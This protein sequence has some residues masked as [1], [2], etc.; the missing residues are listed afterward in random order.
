MRTYP[1]SRPGW[2]VVAAPLL[3]AAP[4]ALA[5]DSGPV[6]VPSAP[7]EGSAPVVAVAAA[8]GALD[9]S[10][11]SAAA[12]ST[13]APALA[14][15]PVADDPVLVGA[16]DIAACG[17]GSE[18]T[19][20]LLD[21][22]PGT[23]VTLGDNAYGSGTAEEYA[24]CYE[25]TWGRHKARTRPAPGNHDYMTASAAPY[26]A[27]FG[28]RAGAPRQSYYSYDLGAWHIVALNSNCDEVGGCEAGS[29]QERWLRVDLAAHPAACTLAY[30]HHPRF[31][32]G[33][34][35]NNRAVQ[36]FWQALYDA[37][38]DVALAGHEHFYERFA[39]QDPAGAA[40]PARGIRQFT[41]G[42]GG[43]S[44]YQFGVVRPNS[45][46]RSAESF[47]VLKLT[48][49]SQG[50]QW[51]FV[52]ADGKPSKDRGSAACHAGARG[53]PAAS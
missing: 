9:T 1:W 25:P 39:P 24:R 3:I 8:P 7:I 17:E 22:I 2:F 53:A 40:D 29:P 38:A 23:V 42:T 45:E 52:A 6:P 15:D 10:A 28:E 44:L 32:S 21:R 41:V 5:P 19:A 36:P 49:G 13:L 27:Y 4:L 20:A 14:A 34:H 50:Y 12:P 51:E 37:G 46:V 18:A 35:G 43:A 31:S 26:F 47:G 11:A 16:G 30:W 33:E 48:L